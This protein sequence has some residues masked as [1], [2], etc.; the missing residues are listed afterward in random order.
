MGH[1][2]H[3]VDLLRQIGGLA[4]PGGDLEGGHAAAGNLHAIQ[5][6]FQTGALVAHGVREKGEIGDFAESTT[7]SHLGCFVG[8]V[9][10]HCYFLQY[11]K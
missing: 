5:R 4:I 3:A 10:S 7:H 8:N 9:L 11:S 6:E 2:D 1:Q